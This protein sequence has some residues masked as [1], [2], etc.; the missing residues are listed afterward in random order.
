MGEKIIVKP[1]DYTVEENGKIGYSYSY[2]N[3]YV[4]AKF[5]N[6]LS[7]KELVAE[8]AKR[9]NEVMKFP[10]PSNISRHALA[11]DLALAKGFAVSQKTTTAKNEEI[12]R[13]F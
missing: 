1:T 3:Q 12:Q 9:W 11:R 13:E 2:D 8:I 5:L 4:D 10:V 6:S 7:E